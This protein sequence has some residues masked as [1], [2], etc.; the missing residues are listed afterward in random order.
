MAGILGS[1]LYLVMHRFLDNDAIYL[2]LSPT[3]LVYIFGFHLTEWSK[4]K[5]EIEEQQAKP[6]FSWAVTEPELQ[7]R[8]LAQHH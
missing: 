8:K 4:A 2:V 3:L 7:I 5:F 6:S 1:S